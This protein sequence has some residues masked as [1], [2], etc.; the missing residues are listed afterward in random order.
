MAIIGV[1]GAIDS[2]VMS[3]KEGFDFFSAVIAVA[4]I[5]TAIYL[6]KLKKYALY[7]ALAIMAF[8]CLSAISIINLVIITPALNGVINKPDFFIYLMAI[9]FLIALSCIWVLLK[10]EVR[11]YVCR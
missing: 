6:I 2:I 3:R 7:S 9:Q 10:K 11:E 4:S 8:M 5:L 1:L